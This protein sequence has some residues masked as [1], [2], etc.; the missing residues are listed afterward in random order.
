MFQQFTSLFL[1][2]RVAALNVSK[3]NL[4][5]LDIWI[6]IIKFCEPLPTPTLTYH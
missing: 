2:T 3:P 6:F 4:Y 1:A 5:F